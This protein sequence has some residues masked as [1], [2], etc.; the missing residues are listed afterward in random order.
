MDVN[1]PRV[2]IVTASYNQAPFIERTIRSVLCQ[3]YGN[4]EYI[5]L[6]SCSQDGTGAI[7]AKYAPAI[8]VLIVEKDRG[9]SDALHRG[10]QLAS[11]GILA[12]L[13]ADDCLA[14][15]QTI[16]QVVQCFAENPAADVIYGRRNFID[17]Q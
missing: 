7:L 4:L 15:A 9:Q 16:S 8:D 13:N 11:G 17:E 6:D 5:V 10:L 14:S 2:S 3:D 1:G 12:Y